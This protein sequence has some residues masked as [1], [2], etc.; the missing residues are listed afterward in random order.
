[1]SEKKQSIWEAYK[2]SI[3]LIGAILIGSLIGIHFGEAAVKLKPLGD[4]FINGMFMIVVP[5][6]FITISSSI[7]GMN[8]M[9]RLGKI[10]KNLFLIFVGTGV[11][12]FF[13]VFVVVKIFPPA[14]GVAL[15]MPAA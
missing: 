8:D 12:A 6:V 13:Y 15:E 11:V 4:L 14:A 5:L 9:N 1:M 10:M 3:L 2:F 7:A